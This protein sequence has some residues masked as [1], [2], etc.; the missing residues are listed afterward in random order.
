MSQAGRSLAVV[1]KALSK[2]SNLPVRTVNQIFNSMVLANLH[3]CGEIWGV[4][5]DSSKIDLLGNRV[6]KL[7]LGVGRNCSNSDVDT[8]WVHKVKA[9]AERVGLEHY[10]LH[11]GYSTKVKKKIVESVQQF[12]YKTLTSDIS[13]KSSLVVFRQLSLF[14]DGTKYLSRRSNGQKRSRRPQV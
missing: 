6:A 5:F 4:D 11:E 14:Q 7:I 12:C 1:T 8:F 10:F 2:Y 13:K 3:Y 9:V